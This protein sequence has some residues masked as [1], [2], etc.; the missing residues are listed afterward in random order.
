M[1]IGH[2][3]VEQPI[4]VGEGFRE[5]RARRRLTIRHLGLTTDHLTTGDWC[6]PRDGGEKADDQ[7]QSGG[8]DAFHGA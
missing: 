5:L 2:E 7:R 6:S 3:P 1:A 8:E 4:H